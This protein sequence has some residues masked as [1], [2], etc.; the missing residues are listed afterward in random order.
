MASAACNIV[1]CHAREYLHEVSRDIRRMK[2]KQQAM[3]YKQL[4]AALQRRML[5]AYMLRDC[6]AAMTVCSRTKFHVTLDVVT[7]VLSRFSQQEMHESMFSPLAKW[8][9][10][11]RRAAEACV[12][13]DVSALNKSG[14]A[15]S[16]DQVFAMYE[17]VLPRRDRRSRTSLCAKRAWAR[18]FRRRWRM[19][20]KPLVLKPSSGLSDIE[21]AAKVGVAKC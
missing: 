4:P 10:A 2:R 16:Y 13:V 3:E 7:D 20:R 5:A 19:A 21:V 12:R 15:P 8:R 1:Q 6:G 9:W 18:R 14:I 11:R 17:A